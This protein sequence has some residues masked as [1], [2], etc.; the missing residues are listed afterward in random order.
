MDKLIFELLSYVGLIVSIICGSYLLQITLRI[1][2]WGLLRVNLSILAITYLLA[3]TLFGLAV[4][5]IDGFA[6]ISAFA[7]YMRPLIILM[8]LIPTLITY[9][10]VKYGPR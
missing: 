1:K 9:G 2:E 3:G 8:E 6:L 4:F 5:G 10:M 7:K